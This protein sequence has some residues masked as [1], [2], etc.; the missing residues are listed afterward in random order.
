MNCQQSCK[1]HLISSNGAILC[2]LCMFLGNFCIVVI[3]VPFL[4]DFV[5]FCAFFLGQANTSPPV[6]TIASRRGTRW[7]HFHLQ[8]KFTKIHKAPKKILS[9]RA[10]LREGEKKSRGQGGG[11]FVG[12]C[13]LHDRHLTQ[14]LT[15]TPTQILQDPRFST[16]PFWGGGLCSQQEP[17]CPFG[18]RPANFLW[19]IIKQVSI[20][21]FWVKWG[22]GD[23][24]SFLGMVCGDFSGWFS[25]HVGV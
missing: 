11:Q 24:E 14:T 8:S 5:C 21:G 6:I 15:L 4:S 13:S 1:F 20:F 10:N 22:G 25:L 23:R 16:L 7:Q 9:D 17:I 19:G 3:F 12:S 2:I 18:L